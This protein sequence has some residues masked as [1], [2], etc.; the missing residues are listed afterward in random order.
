MFFYFLCSRSNETDDRKSYIVFPIYKKQTN[1]KETQ[2]VNL[3]WLLFHNHSL[4]H[5]D[6]TFLNDKFS[7]K[8]WEINHRSFQFTLLII[9][10]DIFLPNLVVYFSKVIKYEKNSRWYSWSCSLHYCFMINRRS[11]HKVFPSGLPKEYSSTL[12]VQRTKS[13]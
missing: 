12:I 11:T 6:A 10:I 13:F 7:L 4:K 9:L 8:W 5:K 1:C 2:H 3:Y